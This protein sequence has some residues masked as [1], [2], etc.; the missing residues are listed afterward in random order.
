MIKG[1]GTDIVEIKRIG[2]IINKNK[3]TFMRKVFSDREWE[4]YKENNFRT[5]S[6]AAGFASKEAVMKVLGIGFRGIS[7]K[8][9]EVLRDYLG[10]PYVNLSGEAFK[11]ACDQDILSVHLSISHSKEY[12]IAFAIGE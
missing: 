1:I 10:K 5:E 6:I 9:I 7:F 2:H 12:A 4:Y 8:D 11:L 3:E